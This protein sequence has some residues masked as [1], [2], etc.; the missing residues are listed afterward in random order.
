MDFFVEFFFYC[1]YQMFDCICEISFNGFFVYLDFIGE[2]VFV[3]GEF[4]VVM[5]FDVIDKDFVDL[6]EYV[7]QLCDVFF[8]FGFERVYYR[9]GFVSCMYVMFNVM[10]CDKVL[11][12]KICGNY[13]N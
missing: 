6:F 12:V 4:I 8:F 11:C 5:G 7:G 2:Q 13:I 3:F 9:F 1:W 10:M